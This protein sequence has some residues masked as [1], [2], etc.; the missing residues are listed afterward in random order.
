MCMLAPFIYTCKDMITEVPRQLSLGLDPFS[1][2]K[3][4]A[5]IQLF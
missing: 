1:N 2:I 3:V 4:T 5:I